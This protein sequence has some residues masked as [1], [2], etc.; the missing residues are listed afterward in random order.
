MPTRVVLDAPKKKQSKS[1]RQNRGVFKVQEVHEQPLRNRSAFQSIRS[2]NDSSAPLAANSK[3]IVKF[4]SSIFRNSSERTTSETA[5]RDTVG[6]SSTD[7]RASPR[8]LGYLYQLLASTVLLITVVKFYQNSQGESIFSRDVENNLKAKTRIYQSIKGPV[9]YWKLIGS[10]IV[11]AAGAGI[12]LLIVLAHVDTIFL[13]RLWYTIFRDSSRYEQNLIR[14]LVI[15]WMCSLHV[16]TS[17]LSVGQVQGNAYFTTWIAFAAAAMNVGIWRVSAGYPSIAEKISLNERATTHN[18]MWSFFFVSTFAG[19]AT[20]TFFNREQ[21][22][23]IHEGKIVHLALGD[24]YKILGFCWFFVFVCIMALLFN[25]FLEKSCELRVL[26][27]SRVILGW[28]QAEGIIIVFMLVVFFW[29]IYGYT[30]VDAVMNGLPNAYFSVWGSF[31]NS[32]FLLGTW[33]R[34]NKKIEYIVPNDSRRI[35]RIYDA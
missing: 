35:N 26:G 21:I 22:P 17:S 27:G 29:I 23:I 18:W 16:C 24:W 13:P 20:D 5:G 25:Q 9:Y 6:L 15:F 10:A 33:L 32:I 3:R 30:G 7:I 14:L 1:A 31:F 2:E 12:S 34:E 28:R 4:R 11:G 8:L 19:A